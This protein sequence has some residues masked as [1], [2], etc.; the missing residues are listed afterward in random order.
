MNDEQTLISLFRSLP[1]EHSKVQFMR[2]ALRV[3]NGDQKALRLGEMVG[4]GQLS[5]SELLKRV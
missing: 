4:A 5:L 3:R 1:D 2:F